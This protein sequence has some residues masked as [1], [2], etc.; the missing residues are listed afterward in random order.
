MSNGFETLHNQTTSVLLDPLDLTLLALNKPKAV[1]RTVPK[2]GGTKVAKTTAA[3]AA[4]SADSYELRNA[5]DFAEYIA[6]HP[7]LTGFLQASHR[8][9]RQLFGPEF[10]FVLEVVRDPETS[11][12][13]A[14]LFVNIRTA[15]PM[16]EA[17][18]RLDQFD[19]NWYLDQVNSFGDLVNFN[20]E[21]YDL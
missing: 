4:R 16:D 10:R 3:G 9:L 11:A 14:Y 7:Q 1:R 17:M 20:L 6:S 5:A 19:E 18:A 21:F 12:P 13:N 8:E 2:G 15:M